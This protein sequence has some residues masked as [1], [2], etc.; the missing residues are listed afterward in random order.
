MIANAGIS[1]GTAGGPDGA[2]LVRRIFAV[3]VDRVLNTVLPASATN[4][5]HIAFPWPMVAAVRLLGLL[6][7]DMLAWLMARLPAKSELTVAASPRPSG[8]SPF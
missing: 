6:T 7:P 3:N 2:D 4:K 8:Q 5:A 1:G